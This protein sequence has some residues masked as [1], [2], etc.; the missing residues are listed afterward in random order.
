MKAFPFILLGSTL[1]IGSALIIGGCINDKKGVALY[2]LIPAIISSIC[3]YGIAATLDPNA[4][5]E[6]FLISPDGWFFIL[7]A[8][9]TSMFALPIVLFRS[10]GINSL[11]SLI[12]DLSGAIVVVVGFVINYF[13]TK[14]DD[15]AQI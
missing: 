11:F 10:K 4:L 13:L 9:I 14:D 15:W 2:I 6:D 3:I 1:T 5:S 8:S 12:L 7:L